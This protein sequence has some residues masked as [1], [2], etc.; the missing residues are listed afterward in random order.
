MNAAQRLILFSVNNGSPV[1]WAELQANYPAS[2]YPNCRATV[3]D[4]GSPYL[5]VISNGTHWLPDGTQI[6]H[7]AGLPVG[8]ASTGTIGNN[9][10]V[11]LGTALPS[12]YAACYLHFPANAIVA[13]SAAGLYFVVMTNTTVG[14]V[15][16]NVY[17]S[18]IPTA[19]A[20]PTAFSTIGPGAYTAA[21]ARTTLITL[22]LPAGIMGLSG[23][24]EMESIW[25]AT[26]N[27]NVKT[28]T[29]VFGSSDLLP[30]P[31]TSIH[32]SHDMRI[33]ANRG[34]AA[35][36]VAFAGTGSAGGWGGAAAALNYGAVNTAV[37]V[38]LKFDAT[39]DTATD[40]LGI[41]SFRV[42]VAA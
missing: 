1:T 20:S 5:S 37:N 12:A 36:Q 14:T 3:S 33:V 30:T 16:N 42:K 7:R 23:S 32:V 22:T 26:N 11:T 21:T 6:L 18:G 27:A 15:Y 8:L 4:Y 35:A 29:A 39:K 28:P 9:G 17:T 38:T 25:S 41:E 13:G 34:S 40:W 31:L 10:A 2:G 24:I 19:P